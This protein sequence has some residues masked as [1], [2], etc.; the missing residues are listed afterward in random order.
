MSGLPRDRAV[1]AQ[2]SAADPGRSV[3]VSANAGT[4]KTTV[5]TNR[6]IRLL[7]AGVSPARIVCLTYTRAAA[8]EMAN[9]LMQRLGSWTA[10][11]EAELRAAL[12][13]LTGEPPEPETIAQARKLFASVLDTPGGLRIDTLHG[14][15][16]GLLRRFPLEAGVAPHFATLE[17]A[18]GVAQEVREAIL[19]RGIAEGASP[20][21]QALALIAELAD[22]MPFASLMADLGG[23]RLRMADL[24]AVS[25]HGALLD[26]AR[27]LL[28]QAADAGDP[29]G[30]LAAAVAEGAFP[31]ARL[32]DAVQA[33]LLGGKTDE[34]KANAIAA[35]LAAAEGQRLGAFDAYCLAYLTAEGAPRASLA[36]KPVLKKHDWLEDVLAG[37]RDRVLA[38]REA[39]AKATALRATAAL[40]RLALDELAAYGAAKGRLSALDFDDLIRGARDLLERPGIAPWVLYKLDGLEHVLIDEAQDTSPAQWR[41]VE[42]LTGEFFAGSGANTG[43]RSI[44]A[45][46]DLKQSI[47]SF[48]GADPDAFAASADRLAARARAAETA[49]IEQPLHVSFRSAPVILDLVDRVFAPAEMR[50]GL[51]REAVA[52]QAAREGQAG[53]VELWPPEG[54]RKEDADEEPDA[55]ASG[56]EA[57]TRQERQDDP[58]E[59]LALRIA[60]RI[61]RWLD[62]GEILHARGRAVR[63]GDIMILLR[64]RDP[65]GPAIVRALKG[66]AVPVAGSDRLVLTSHL[67]VMD[68]LALARAVLLPQDDLN[69]ATVL[70]GPLIGWDDEALFALAHERGPDRLWT[71]LRARASGDGAAPDLVRAHGILAEVMALAD[72][73]P[74]FEFFSHVLGPMCGRARLAGRLGPEAIDAID[75]F[76]AQALAFER[77]GVPSLQS[78]VHWI[79]RN[80]PEAK[81][82]MERGR[83]EV[84]VLTVHASKGLEAPIVILPDTCAV[85]TIAGALV[86]PPDGPPLWA[87]GVAK[88]IPP[89]V[90][91]RDAAKAA[92]EAEQRRLLYVALT[93]AED[94]LYIAGFH[95]RRQ[96]D[97]QSWYRLVEPAFA[98]AE[99]VVDEDGQV[100]RRFAHQQ[101]GPP[102]HRPEPPARTAAVDDLPAFARRP[103][104]PPPDEHWLAP[105]QAAAA[106]PLGQ[107]GALRWQ[108]GRL[109]HRLLQTLPDL[110]PGA[111]DPAARR[112]LAEP[113]HG[114]EAAAQ[115]EIAGETLALLRDPQTADLFGPGSRAEVPLCGR[116]DGR[117]VTGQVDRLRVAADGIQVIDFKTSRPPPLDVVK[118]DPAYILQMALYRALLQAIHPGRPVRAGLI[119]TFGPRLM[120]LPDALMER[121]LAA[122]REPPG[123]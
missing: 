14:F 39:H 32:R 118:V 90:A 6:M 18:A 53:L 16:Q 68:L 64:R 25:D 24:A 30:I 57:P 78:F 104:P 17:D 8:A 71:V 22:E 111:R 37:E 3:W 33:L 27:S 74:P 7:L 92:R 83:D 36:T 35:F 97:A 95:G 98:E 15:C 79:A 103:A 107:A 88:Q 81:R 69:L 102:Q 117:F 20:L 94:R 44:F 48:Q 51:G 62:T 84:R 122:S 46:G 65:F 40:L 106:S 34:D 89:L 101:V 43:R 114:L 93:R 123:G 9:R 12:V 58:C 47:F 56:F 29:E 38:V 26:A 105:S 61:R 49:F 119:W 4:G 28:A 66:L 10:M 70:K 19:A 42:A 113:G 67:A 85:P 112:W 75:E 80:E 63:P 45:V 23:R 54:P 77:E 82:D 1:L 5:L 55:A 59:R 108:R 121:A 11:P 120:W 52:H 13:A 31:R 109:I 21:G 116:I 41:L 73:V 96:P 60:R 50:A 115:D 2:R 100:V 110:E 91:L 86:W 72:R 87:P 76:L 99:Q